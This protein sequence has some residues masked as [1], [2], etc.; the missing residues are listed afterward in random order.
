M[1]RWDRHA[2]AWIVA[3]RVGWL[4]PVFRWLSY[5]GTDGAVWL[6]IAALLT[7]ATRRR[8]PLL[9]V[10]AVDAVA[11]VLTPGLQALFGR[12]RPHVVTLVAEPHSRSFPSGHSSSSFACEL[13]LASF[14]PRLRGALLALAAAIAFS[15]LYV[16][17]HY[18]LDVLGGV[19]LGAALGW[20][21]LQAARL[22]PERSTDLRLR[23]AGRRRSRQDRQP[24]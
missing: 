18:P 1:L 20:A 11:Q 8:G 22:A 10:A 23:G 15:R 17:V 5:A 6:A 19:A 9:W 12:P 24:N 16:G 14:A 2:E 21:T 4:D 13:V 3:H 7:L